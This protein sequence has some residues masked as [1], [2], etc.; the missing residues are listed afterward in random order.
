MK[1]GF[2]FAKLFITPE[3]GV[4][5]NQMDAFIQGAKSQFGIDFSSVFQ[6]VPDE[7]TRLG[8]FKTHTRGM[9]LKFG[10]MEYKRPT[11]ILYFS[12]K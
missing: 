10:K 12:E 2:D 4:N 8:I 5:K 7:K 1:I 11:G 9:P 3:E 6:P